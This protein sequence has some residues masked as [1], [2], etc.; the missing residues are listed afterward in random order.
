MEK[1]PQP[2]T[3][4]MY[5]PKKE[6]HREPFQNSQVHFLSCQSAS[7]ANTTLTQVRMLSYL[8]ILA[9]ILL[10]QKNSLSNSINVIKGKFRLDIRKKFSE[11]GQSLD[12]AAQ[13][14]GY[15]TKP[16]RGQGASGQCFQSYNLVLGSVVRSREVGQMMLVGSFNLQIFCDSI[17]NHVRMSIALNSHG[18]ANGKIPRIM[19]QYLQ[20]IYSNYLL[21]K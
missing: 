13:T 19:R 9:D 4:R 17:N 18:R 16:F 2:V 6:I 11:G 8:E 5:S 15:S 10:Q 14:S 1:K 7:E 3:N 21:T 12:K 20:H